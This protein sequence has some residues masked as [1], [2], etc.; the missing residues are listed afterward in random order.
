MDYTAESAGKDYDVQFS[1]LVTAAIGASSPCTSAIL[2][3][4]KDPAV[5]KLYIDKILSGSVPEGIRCLDDI[6]IPEHRSVLFE[7]SCPNGTVCLI[8][9]SFVVVVNVV[10]GVVEH[11]IDPYI[12]FALADA[13]RASISIG[14]SADEWEVGNGRI[15][16]RLR[17][18]VSYGGDDWD[19]I[20]SRLTLTTSS[21][22][23]E[24]SE[25]SNRLFKVKN[26]KTCVIFSEGVIEFCC[27]ARF[28]PVPQSE[29]DIC[30]K[31]SI[32]VAMRSACGPCDSK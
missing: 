19:F 17:A 6:G 2:I 5:R 27:T 12:P 4:A 7:F 29:T 28:R 21:L 26:I 9:P 24:K 18:T 30:K 32:P 11:I 13:T 23:E 25:V 14:V 3:A 8:K 31:I 10:Y 22:C 1:Q 20:D 16:V 15:S